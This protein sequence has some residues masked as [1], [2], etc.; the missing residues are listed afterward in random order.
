MKMTFTFD[1][2]YTLTIDTCNITLTPEEMEKVFTV[3]I[4]THG[5]IVDVDVSK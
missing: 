2:N 3:F 5:K 4:V 1:D